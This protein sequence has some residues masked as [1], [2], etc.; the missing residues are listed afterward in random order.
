MA[1]SVAEPVLVVIAFASGRHVES[2]VG[3]IMAF[4]DDFLKRQKDHQEHK[5]KVRAAA[6]ANSPPGIHWKFYGPVRS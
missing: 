6:A 1:S 2:A 5:E 3:A 4:A